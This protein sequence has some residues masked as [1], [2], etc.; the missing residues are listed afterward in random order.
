MPLVLGSV[1]LSPTP[2]ARGQTYLAV[3]SF[4][5]NEANDTQGALANLSPQTL[6]GAA[7]FGGTGAGSIFGS[8]YGGGTTPMHS[9]STTDGANPYAGL[10]LNPADNFLYG[11]AE[12]GGT[13]SYGV[14]YKIDTSGNNFSVIHNLDGSNDGGHPYGRLV[15][16]GS[17]LYGVARD[18]GPNGYGT[19]FSLPT[20][21]STFARVYAFGS[22]TTD[23][24]HPYGGLLVGDDGRLYGT[25]EE[26]HNGTGVGTV[27]GVNANGTGFATLHTFTG[28]VDGQDPQAPLIE[29]SDGFLYG[30]TLFGGNANGG[31]AYKLLKDG[32]SYSV[33]H[34]FAGNATEGGRPSV[35]TQVPNGLLYGTTTSDGQ[36]GVGTIYLMTPAGQLFTPQHQFADAS[37][38]LA[39]GGVTYGSDG[40]LYGAT[41]TGGQNNVGVLFQYTIPTIAGFPTPSFG[42]ATGGTSVT[43]T[44]VGFQTGATVTFGGSQAP[45]PSIGAK[46]ITVNSPAL[47]AGTLNDIIVTNP[48]STSALWHNAWFSE[49]LDVPEGDPFFFY[50][51]DIFRAGITAGCGGGNYC[52]NTPVTRAQMAVFLLKGHHNHIFPYYGYASPFLP[53]ACTGVFTDVECTPTPAFA[54]NWIEQLY[55]EGITGGCSVSPLEYCPNNSVTRAQMAVFLL[56]AEHGSGYVPPACTGVFADVECSPTP[57]FAV[58]WIEQLYHEN[59]TGGCSVSPLNYCPGNPVTRGQMAVFLAKVFLPS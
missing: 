55:A 49:F 10:L 47:P 7:A 34:A 2:P 3:H 57:A 43:I 45:G 29:L 18:V 32:S 35:L 5:T 22:G 39:Y 13:S 36:N 24:S 28:G 25:T 27:F 12:N 8:L 31:T 15:L 40:N 26:G 42:P 59:I 9:F 33:F 4:A 54:V 56:K 58:D 37:G 46:S 1:L 53:P 38:A 19:I 48:D 41:A 11:V 52:R 30:T 16:I 17:T 14:V 20:D 23:G 44:G 51:T 50:V 6:Y 21:G